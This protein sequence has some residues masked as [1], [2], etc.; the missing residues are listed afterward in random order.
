MDM[1][2]SLENVECIVSFEFLQKEL[3]VFGASVVFQKVIV[4]KIFDKRTLMFLVV[5]G[6][7]KYCHKVKNLEFAALRQNLIAF[8]E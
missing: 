2:N 7:Q 3:D 4:L 6:Q 8:F 5:G 1:E